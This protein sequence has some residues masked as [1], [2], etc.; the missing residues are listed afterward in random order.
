ML[1]GALFISMMF[2]APALSAVLPPR[3]QSGD[4]AYHAT[5]NAWTKIDLVLPITLFGRTSHVAWVSMNGIFTIDEPD[6]SL[7]TVP[8]RPLP[9]NPDD[10]KTSPGGCIPATAILPF[11]ADLVLRPPLTY[12]TQ[13]NVEMHALDHGNTAEEPMGRKQ[14]YHLFWRVCDKSM[15]MEI[16]NGY[17]A[18]TYCGQASRVFCMTWGVGAPG[19]IELTY[20]N[21]GL[22]LATAGTIGIQS[23]NWHMSV[24]ASDI[25]GP[26]LHL[27]RITIDT[28]TLNYTITH[29]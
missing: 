19:V 21:D 14:H 15:P 24:A 20:Y 5:D 11:W 23:P 1:P 12:I 18:Y 13:T 7:P 16:P 22:S 26:N 8:E 3:A 4:P 27:T 17:P 25:F 2:A 6:M 10:C 9:V 28:N 29:S